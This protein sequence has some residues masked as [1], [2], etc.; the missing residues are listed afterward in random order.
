MTK[1]TIFTVL[2]SVPFVRRPPPVG[3]MSLRPRLPTLASGLGVKR[4]GP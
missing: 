2:R 1:R 3:Y 4:K